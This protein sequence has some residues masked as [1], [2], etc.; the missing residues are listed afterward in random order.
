MKLTDLSKKDL[1][2]VRL[3]LVA[4]Q[5]KVTK[6]D[7]AVADL[8]GDVERGV[9]KVAAVDK[10]LNLAEALSRRC[11][12]VLATA[13]SKLEEEMARRADAAEGADDEDSSEE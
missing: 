2:D 8:L 4:L 10:A 1:K 9:L 6:L 5:K 13:V 11:A 3:E 7:S 12:Y